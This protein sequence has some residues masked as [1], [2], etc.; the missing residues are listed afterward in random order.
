MNRGTI[1][2]LMDEPTLV[3]A[4]LDLETPHAHVRAHVEG[5]HTQ[6]GDVLVRSVKS[7]WPAQHD[8]AR[9]VLRA[10]VPGH[11][12][13]SLLARLRSARVRVAVRGP[14]PSAYAEPLTSFG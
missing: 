2:A 5:T 3:R 7:A 9:T 12:L 13:S 14:F 1:A 10:L 11:A 6:Q 4:V 8:E